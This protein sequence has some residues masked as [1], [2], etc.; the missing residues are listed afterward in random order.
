MN[1]YITCTTFIVVS[2][3][4]TFFLNNLLKRNNILKK[5]VTENELKNVPD[6]V[7]LYIKNK[8]EGKASP[9]LSLLKCFQEDFNEDRIVF[10]CFV[11]AREELTGE[12]EERRLLLRKEGNECS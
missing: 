10:V 2:I 5:N 9:S 4:Y 1:N 7:L 3:I 12:G 6:K 11:C 8:E